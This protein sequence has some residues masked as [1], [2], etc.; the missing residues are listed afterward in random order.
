MVWRPSINNSFAYTNAH[1][2]REREREFKM[3]Y[4]KVEACDMETL[5][6]CM[7]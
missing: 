7:P 6:E 4:I 5:Y 3:A 1:R 2:E